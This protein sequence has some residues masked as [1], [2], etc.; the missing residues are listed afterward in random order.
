MTG[1]GCDLTV[2]VLGGGLTPHLSHQTGGGNSERILLTR[3][4]YSVQERKIALTDVGEIIPIEQDCKLS[5][6]HSSEDIRAR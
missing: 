4:I 1:A 3:N 2:G 6:M 5:S